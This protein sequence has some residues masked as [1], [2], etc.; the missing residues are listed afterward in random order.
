MRSV[1][2]MKTA[3]ISYIV[4]SVLFGALGISLLVMPQIIF[5]VLAEVFGALLIVFGA[6][7][8]IGYFSRDL[9]RLAFQHDLALGLLLIAL[10]MITILKTDQLMVFISIVTGIYVLAD[11]LLKI[12]TAFDARIFGI[13]GWWLILAAAVLAGFAGG[14]LIFRPYKGAEFLTMMLGICFLTEGILNLITVLTAVKIIGHQ[15]PDRI[16]VTDMTEFHEQGEA[17]RRV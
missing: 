11:G 16:D 5:P 7:K 9:F 3:K 14:V 6:V 1:R 4:I 17:G 13:E 10:G 12:Q 8:L 15:R 2:G